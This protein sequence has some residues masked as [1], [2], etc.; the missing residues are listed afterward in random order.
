M[1][2][3]VAADAMLVLHLAFI[4]FALFGGLLALRWPRLAWLHLAAATWAVG[5]ECLGG[6]CP[7]TTI[8]Q[9]LLR[10]AGEAGYRGGFVEHYLV[11]LIYPPGLTR[12]HQTVLGAIVLAVNVAIYAWVWR[13]RRRTGR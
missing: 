1:I 8:E 2:A 3:R 9:R 6:I 10:A 12:T 5:I 7:L 4:V 13:R 11:P